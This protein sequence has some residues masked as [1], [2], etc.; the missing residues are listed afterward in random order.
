MSYKSLLH[1]Y[2]KELI[3]LR[4]HF[5]RFPE[6]A[7][8]EFETAS[9]IES[10][11][12]DC[13]LEVKRGL[14]KTGLVGLL[15]GTAGPTIAFRAEMDG[16]P[17]NE[18]NQVGYRS[19]RA[20]VMHA[21]GHDGHMAVALITAKILSKAKERLKGNVMFV[22]QPAEENLPEGG[23]KRMLAEGKDLFSNIHAIFGFHFW[24]SLATGTV[25][26]SKGAMMAAGDIFEVKF[27]GI[28]AHVANHYQ[29]SDVPMMTSEAVL[30]LTSIALR[31]VEPGVLSTMSI[32]V[33][34]S[35]RYPNVL[36]SK[37]L[38]KGTTRYVDDS[39]REFFPKTI[40]RIVDG[41]CHAYN[42]SYDLAYS[43]GYP[44]LRNDQDMAKKVIG[45]A[46][47]ANFVTSVIEVTTPSLT[48]EDFAVYLEKLPGCYYWVGT[49]NNNSE[50]V[51]LLHNSKFDIDEGALFTATEMYL[52]ICEQML[53]S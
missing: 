51:N 2:K 23:A 8:E 41:I 27:T 5:H 30:A 43:Y 26:V 36:P 45:I 48:S 9:Y 47:K 53:S 39:F 37:S 35:G 1:Q 34:C 33:I 15:R 18:E 25:A 17:I 29:S 22:F 3:D 32:G 12:K 20:N 31:N 19:T 11:L 40:S 13:G 42:A 50:V 52:S 28:G 21:C 44:V 24:P 7:N 10:Y 6:L 16:L 49:Q 4:R 46:H 38:I 14:A